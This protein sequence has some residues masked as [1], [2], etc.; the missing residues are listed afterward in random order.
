MTDNE[1]AATYTDWKPF[2]QA[3]WGEWADE[4]GNVARDMS[5][6][7]NYMKALE[8]VQARTHHGPIEMTVECDR[9]KGWKPVKFRWLVKLYKVLEDEHS[10]HDWLEPVEALAALHDAE[11]AE[12]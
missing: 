7:R 8:A 6:P 12:R 5:D 10:V 2:S 1:K 9:D 11:H 3:P 4:H